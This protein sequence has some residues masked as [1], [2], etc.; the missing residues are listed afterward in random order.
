MVTQQSN[1]EG[2]FISTAKFSG[3]ALQYASNLL[4]DQYTN[5]GQSKD[6]TAIA[7]RPFFDSA[8]LISHTGTHAWDSFSP[9][10]NAFPTFSPS[11]R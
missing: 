11:T 5:S 1:D 7:V 10:L 6:R 8:T 4:W 9:S 2:L 3:G